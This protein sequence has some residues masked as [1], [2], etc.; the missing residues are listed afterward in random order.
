MRL[1]LILLRILCDLLETNLTS[2]L[3]LHYTKR[4]FFIQDFFCK[5]D[6][7]RRKLKKSLM[8]N[9]IF[10]AVLSFYY[11][12]NES[13]CAHSWKVLLAKNLYE[14]SLIGKNWLYKKQF[15]NFTKQTLAMSLEQ[16]IKI[17]RIFNKTS[18]S[19]MIYHMMKI[20]IS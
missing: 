17:F 7:I 8:E 5:C 9:F 14:S 1:V 20:K 18:N 3:T 2:M 11:E 13:N 4:N 12:A 15:C 6:Q 16:I 10:C 19:W